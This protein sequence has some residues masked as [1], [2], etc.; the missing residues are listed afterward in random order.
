[1]CCCSSGYSTCPEN[2]E[3]ATAII[4][5]IASYERRCPQEPTFDDTLKIM[6]IKEASF[7]L[8]N[9]NQ[10]I[11]FKIEF[12]CTMEHHIMWLMGSCYL[13]MEGVAND[14]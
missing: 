4:K 10:L 13:V 7:G 2:T 14:S 8:Y 1:M 9:D 12:I 3:R 11:I 6:V 5:T